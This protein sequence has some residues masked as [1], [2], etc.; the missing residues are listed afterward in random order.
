M[1]VVAVVASIYVFVGF[2]VGWA[3]RWADQSK[4]PCCDAEPANRGWWDVLLGAT[5]WPLS[6]LSFIAWLCGGDQK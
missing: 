3:L 4:C 5:L 1:K 2:F 6:A